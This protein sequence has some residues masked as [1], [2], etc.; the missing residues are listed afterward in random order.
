L[1][2]PA[3]L[4]LFQIAEAVVIDA[5]ADHALGGT[6]IALPWER[7]AASLAKVRGGA[8]LS[9]AG[10]LTPSNVGRAVVALT[11]DIVDVSSGVESSPGVKDHGL[12]QAF[13]VAVHGAMRAA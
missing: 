12:M 9:L 7:L 10:G 5:R 8:R 6:G 11:P 1:V 13:M 3:A 4:E 2:P